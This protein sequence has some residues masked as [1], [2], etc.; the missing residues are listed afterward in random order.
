LA[1]EDP[2]DEDDFNYGNKI[3]EDGAAEHG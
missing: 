3:G 1:G 2:F